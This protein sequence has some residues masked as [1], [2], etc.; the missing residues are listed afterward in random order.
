MTIDY[1]FLRPL[2]AAALK[3]WY[4]APFEKKENLQV[5]TYKNA[6]ILPL[7]RLE[8]DNLLFGR[9]G[10]V[11]ETG[12]YINLSAING[13][14]QF[15]Y[16]FT[17]TSF[18]NEK[19][20]YCGY[21]VD[22][23]GHFLIES[24][25]RLWF[26]LKN[27]SS[28]D[29]YVFF[30]KEN[31]KREIS[32]NY[33]EFFI[34]LGIWDKISVINQPTRYKEVVIPELG[35]NRTIYYSEQFK[36]IFSKIS[37]TANT[38]HSTSTISTNH[39]KIFFSRSQLKN[40][41]KREFGLEIIDNYFQKNGYTILYPEK[42]SLSALVTYIKNAQEIAMFSGSVHHNIL[43]AEDNKKIILIE[44]NVLNNEIQ[45][46]INRMKN[47]SVDY[48][49][50]NM[51]VYTVNLSAGPFILAYNKHLGQYTSSKKLSPPDSKYYNRKYI[52]KMFKG[53]MNSYTKAYKFQWYMDDW[54]IKYTNT[55]REGYNESFQHLGDFLTGRKPF[56]LIHYLGL[57]FWNLKLQKFI[58]FLYSKYHK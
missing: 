42:I 39:L 50:A 12:D 48:I 23:W 2:K 32:G 16:E 43:F 30:V 34:L 3:E 49:D 40:I 10:V 37:S 28:V 45:V 5:E 17:D 20:V 15:S 1:S 19:V 56:R 21:L 52:K 57:H 27:D 26:F 9:G 36:E 41:N 22:Q 8:S 11:S 44:R 33:R 54:Y 29:R 13:R 47:L 24:V 25:A 53:Y 4:E 35:Y 46:D 38:N 31:E 58:L 6:T 55:F 14:I 18:V 7:K 51:P